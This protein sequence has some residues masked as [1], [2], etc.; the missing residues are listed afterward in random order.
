MCEVGY[1][2][3]M[4]HLCRARVERRILFRVSV[5][6]EWKSNDSQNLLELRNLPILTT[7]RKF[8]SWKILGYFDPIFSCHKFIDTLKPATIGHC[9]DG[10]V[11]YR[12]D[13]RTIYLENWNSVT[14]FTSSSSFKQIFKHTALLRISL[15]LLIF[16]SLCVINIFIVKSLWLI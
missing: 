6:G 7:L 5:T 4:K 2:F 1:N 13:V 15:N 9:P 12:D 11:F 14:S 10:S 3:I 16:L 8:I